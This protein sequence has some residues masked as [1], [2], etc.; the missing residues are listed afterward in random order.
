M[1]DT[2]QTRRDLTGGSST[3]WTLR[4]PFPCC[5]PGL[6]T[7]C[8]RRILQRMGIKRSRAGTRMGLGEA[9]SP[10]ELWLSLVEVVGG[11]DPAPRAIRGCRTL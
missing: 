1:R 9:C 2:V 3:S 7:L 10:P 6:S 5:I 11:Q 8:Q 4:G